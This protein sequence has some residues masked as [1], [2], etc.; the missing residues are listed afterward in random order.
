MPADSPL[1]GRKA[2]AFT[3]A[4]HTGTQRRLS[5]FAGYRVVYFYPRANTPGC[6]TEACEFTD[7]IDDFAHLDATV[8]GISPDTTEA[9]AKF[10]DKRG[11]QVTLLSDP[12]HKIMEKYG[13]WGEKRMF[14]KK[15]MGVKRSTV[16]IDPSGKVVHHWRSVKAKGHAEKVRQ[17]L[18]ELCG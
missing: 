13:A 11:L 6:T 10:I 7:S 15:T 18:E 14:G 12:D 4:D 5:D 1:V 2:P 3:L 17:K 9:L 8:I 16:L